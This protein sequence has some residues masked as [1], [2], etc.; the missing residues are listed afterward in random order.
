MFL[1]QEFLKARPEEDYPVIAATAPLGVAVM[2]RRLCVS[3]ELDHAFYRPVYGDRECNYAEVIP[4]LVN[5]FKEKANDVRAHTL[6]QHTSC[7]Y[8]F[9]YSCVTL[10]EG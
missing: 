9:F 8:V 3:S 2:A 6:V 10:K 1:L 4:P 7:S 5:L